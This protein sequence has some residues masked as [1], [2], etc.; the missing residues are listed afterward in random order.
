M[1]NAPK[2]SRTSSTIAR[3]SA[4]ILDDEHVDAGQRAVTVA[5]RLSGPVFA[6]PRRRG[7]RAGLA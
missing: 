7:R 2:Y 6:A 4:W 5:H 3:A 1:T